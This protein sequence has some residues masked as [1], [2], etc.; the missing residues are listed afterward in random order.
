M[1]TVNVSG[2]VPMEFS[3][4]K[5]CVIS[6]KST[7]SFDEAP[8]ICSLLVKSLIEFFARARAATLE[9]GENRFR[10]AS[11]AAFSVGLRPRAD[12]DDKIASSSL[13]DDAEA[14]DRGKWKTRL[15]KPV[16][17]PKLA[18]HGLAIG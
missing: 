7:T 10:L 13:R 8:L 16:F 12:Q 2:R 1:N 11:E 3:M 4:S 5:Y 6:N 15:E 18:K 9:P 14:P 17:L